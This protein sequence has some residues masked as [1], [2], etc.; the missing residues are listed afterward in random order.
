[1]SSTLT[2]RG[3]QFSVGRATDPRYTEVRTR[4]SLPVKGLRSVQFR[5]FLEQRPQSTTDIQFAMV[6]EIEHEEDPAL[7]NDCIEMFRHAA[8]GVCRS[9]LEYREAY[10]RYEAVNG[11]IAIT[12]N[13][14][15]AEWN[16]TFA[17]LCPC[18]HPTASGLPEHDTLTRTYLPFAMEE[19]LGV[20]L[21]QIAPP[22]GA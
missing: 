18:I 14:S 8:I 17:I 9:P 21:D 19:A 5:E 15:L 13:F 22:E 4:I 3:Q 20:L 11:H 6:I 2:Y 12:L 10:A 1:M 16:L 7:L